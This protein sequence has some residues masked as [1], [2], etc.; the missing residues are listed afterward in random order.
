[1]LS[2]V[3]N[4]HGLRLGVES[5]IDPERSV[6]RIARLDAVSDADERGIAPSSPS[7]SADESR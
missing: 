5:I 3:D 6:H 4:L 1:V 7:G 2:S